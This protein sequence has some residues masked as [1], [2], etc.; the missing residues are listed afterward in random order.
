MERTNPDESGIDAPAIPAWASWLGAIAVV[1]GLYLA[2]DFGVEASRQYVLDFPSQEAWADSWECP[3]DELEEEGVS[4]VVCDEMASQVS[5]FLVARPDWFR[6]FQMGVALAGTGLALLSMVSA[7][8]LLNGRAWAPMATV[9]VFTAFAVLDAV[10]LIA[11]ANGN[12]MLRDMYLWQWTLWL[13]LHIAL[14]V[15]A[16]AGSQKGLS[17][18]T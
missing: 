2:A 9:A 12:P 7:L 17:R 13:M 18:E 14:A 15:A 8:G 16:Y 5:S 10:G 1:L 11:V 6:G 4:P 3:P